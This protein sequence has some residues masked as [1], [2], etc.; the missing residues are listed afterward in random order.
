LRRQILAVDIATPCQSKYSFSWKLA[1]HYL[2]FSGI[3]QKFTPDNYL[4]L[5]EVTFKPL[6]ENTSGYRKINASGHQILLNYR[7]SNEV[8]EKVTLREILS[9]QFDTERIK[10]RV[11]LIGTTDPSFGDY[12][13]HTPYS[14]TDDSVE[15]L[16]GVEIQAHMVSHILSA[17]LD[18]RTLIWSLSKPVEAM[19]ILA[20]SLVGSLLAWRLMS[21][22]LI[23]L[24]ALCISCW[25]LL[26]FK[27]G[28]IPLVPP[29]L[30]LITAGS[31]LV[32]YKYKI[33]AKT[34]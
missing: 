22:H 17:V 1:T 18:K 11:V 2:A 34:D 33:S 12:R 29:A 31:C 30:A 32:I 20:W 16:A 13:W 24:G 15:T 23:L 27:G 19:W 8:A 3:K 4:K 14:S 21:P 28:W 10:N 6:E 9:N 25:G 5:G 26:I 7:A